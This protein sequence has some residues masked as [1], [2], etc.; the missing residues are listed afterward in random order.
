M[1]VNY[2]V[3]SCHPSSSPV[4]SNTSSVGFRCGLLPGTSGTLKDPLQR[5]PAGAGPSS[6]PNFDASGQPL[7]VQ[8]GRGTSHRE[9]RACNVW[10]PRNA[11]DG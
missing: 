5:L 1:I 2:S 6:L 7:M 4:L 11:A 10:I 3:N 8:A 9:Q